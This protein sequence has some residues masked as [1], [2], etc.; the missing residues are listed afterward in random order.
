MDQYM[1]VNGMKIKYLDLEFIHGLME[2]SMKVNGQTILCMEKDHIL[3]QMVEII[4]EIIIWIKK[5]DTEFINGL[6]IIILG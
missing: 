1:M 2:G 4:Q 6:N 3:G 5:K